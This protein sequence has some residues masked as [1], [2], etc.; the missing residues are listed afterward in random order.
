V[1]LPSSVVTEAVA[2]VGPVAV[3]VGSVRFGAVSSALRG[4][5]APMYPPSKPAVSS[6]KFVGSGQWM[7]CRPDQPP[8][9][10]SQT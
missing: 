2:V 8:A 1:P 9:R 10:C 5:S 3:A 4:S 6:V 7:M